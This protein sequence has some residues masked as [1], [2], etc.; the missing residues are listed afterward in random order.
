M[1]KL[2]ILS[3]LL[4]SISIN[5]QKEINLDNS[6]SGSLNQG[7]SNIVGSL[8]LHISFKFLAKSVADS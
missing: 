6:L 5:A 4:L 7:K 3:F 2:I 1:K 8:D